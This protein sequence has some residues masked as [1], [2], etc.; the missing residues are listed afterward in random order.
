MK[1]I[2]TMTKQNDVETNPEV[3]GCEC[4]DC[5]PDL[6]TDCECA[7]HF[8]DTDESDFVPPTEEE[9]NQ[10]LDSIINELF[11]TPVAGPPDINALFDK[12]FGK[13]K[14]DN[15]N[16]YPIDISFNEE[17]LR[18]ISLA[19]RYHGETMVLTVSKLLADE[20]VSIIEQLPQKQQEYV[21]TLC[22]K[23]LATSEANLAIYTFLT[24][25]FGINE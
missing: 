3:S 18:T 8:P 11:V 7:G 17:E 1:E 5:R 22:E 13:K 6:Y 12:Y 14:E 21:A 20:N 19:L 2:L 4:A 15:L 25:T 24:E 23:A 16:E 10:E 9:I